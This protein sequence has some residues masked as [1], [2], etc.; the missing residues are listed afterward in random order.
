MYHAYKKTYFINLSLKKNQNPANS[1]ILV[2]CL[3]TTIKAS[4]QLIYIYM[5]LGTV[6]NLSFSISSCT[7]CCFCLKLPMTEFFRDATALSTWTQRLLS[8]LQPTNPTQ[9]N[10][11]Q[12]VENRHILFSVCL[13][14]KNQNH[15]KSEFFLP[16]NKKKNRNNN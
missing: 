11:L 6:K 7:I 2:L 13:V 1:Q 15:N 12:K 8:G 14:F 16:F 3:P 10:Q 9:K 4:V 5:L